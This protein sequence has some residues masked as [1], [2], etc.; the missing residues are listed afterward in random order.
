MN[1]RTVNNLVLAAMFLAIGMILPFFTGQINEIGGSLLPMHLP[2][3]LCG[4]VC[5]WQYG[6]VVGFVLPLLR[7]VIFGMPP[8][9]PGAVS[10]AFELASYGLVIG[11]IY[12][13]FQKKTVFSVYASLLSAMI[14][15]R[16][17]RGLVQTILLGIIG[18]KYTFAAFWI[19][20]FADALPGILL[21]L[22]LIPALMILINKLQQRKKTL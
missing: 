3:L 17:V 18:K 1:K 15:G 12:G 16:L 11:V 13:L 2:V 4:L 8:L 14:T 7:S 5:G 19:G 9:Y 10:M 22:I 21:Q 6:S 20:G